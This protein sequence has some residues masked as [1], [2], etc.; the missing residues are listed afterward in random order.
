MGR[1]DPRLRRVVVKAVSNSYPAARVL[2]R[3]EALLL[4]IFA[5]AAVVEEDAAGPTR[6]SDDS[7]AWGDL[8]LAA[9]TV[10]LLE[11]HV[12]A[13]FYFDPDSPTGGFH[14]LLL[15]AC[16]QFHG[17][18]SLSRTSSAMINEATVNAKALTAKGCIDKVHKHRLL[19]VIEK[20]CD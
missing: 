4:R 9:P 1:I 7:A 17:L 6:D 16:A 14:R 20:G 3:F 19:D 5:R 2:E 18:E 12:V 11:N 13:H 8:L 15:H 10:E